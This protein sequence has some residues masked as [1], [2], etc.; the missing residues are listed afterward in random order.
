M[1]DEP[2]MSGD[3]KRWYVVN[4]PSTREYNGPYSV[5]DLTTLV[6]SGE[7]DIRNAWAFTKGDTSMI[8]LNTIPGV[9]RRSPT[10]PIEVPIPDSGDQLWYIAGANKVPIGPYTL[11][12]LQAQLDRSEITRD[13]YVWKKG[14]D[15]WIYLH[16]V[17]GF[18]RRK[19]S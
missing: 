9:D 8:P 5:K 19:S 12:E 13:T 18:D 11:S 4:D 14:L 15:K 10:S 17:P 1:S 3:D 16:Q 2:S 6:E 7:I